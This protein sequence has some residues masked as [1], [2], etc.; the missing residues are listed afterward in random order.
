MKFDFVFDNYIGTRRTAD[1]A[2]AFLK[3]LFRHRCLK[4]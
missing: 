1:I 2:M 4:S 3:F